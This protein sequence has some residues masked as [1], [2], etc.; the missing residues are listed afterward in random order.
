VVD[1][2]IVPDTS[3]YEQLLRD[4]QSFLEQPPQKITSGKRLAE[5]MG[6]KARRICEDVIDYFDEG[7]PS[8]E[9]LVKIYNLMRQLLVHDLDR[10]RFAD[11]YAQTL[12]YGLFV[13]RYNDSTPETF[14]RNEARGLVPKTNPFLL[15]FFDHIVGPTFDERLARAVDELCEVFRVSDVRRLVQRHI[16]GFKGKN[17]RDP[18][19]HFYEDFL[20]AYDSDLRR[21]M[22]AYYTPLPVVRYMVRQVDSLLKSEFAIRKGLADA[23]KIRYRIDDGQTRRYKD[24]LTGRRRTMRG[25][26]IDLHRVQILDPAVG[27]ATFLNEIIEFIYA[28]FK[29]G[30]QGRWPQ[31]ADDHLI[32]RLNGFEYMMAPYTIAHLK[33]GMTLEESGVEALKRRLRVFLTNSLE[34]GIRHQPDLFS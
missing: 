5:L 1:G 10:R 19:I 22:G 9:D 25:Q 29:T 3:K 16:Y 6:A 8:N 31:Y 17:N 2:E 27:T 12:V 21:A 33:L 14:S 11:M 28:G 30:Q 34:E 23:S 7:P 4:L 20:E 26:E 32:P 13:A 24:H 18:I 15:S